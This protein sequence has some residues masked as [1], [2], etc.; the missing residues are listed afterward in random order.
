M[1]YLRKYNENDEYDENTQNSNGYTLDQL[2][3]LRDQEMQDAADILSDTGNP[4]WETWANSDPMSVLIELEKLGT[5][6][7]RA[8]WFILKDIQNQIDNFPDVVLTENRSVIPEGRK[9]FR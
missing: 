3:Q 9:L 5:D 4:A 8:I 1:K 7:S 2:H 6:S